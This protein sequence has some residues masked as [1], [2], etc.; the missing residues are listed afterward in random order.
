MGNSAQ[1]G[2]LAWTGRGGISLGRWERILGELPSLPRKACPSC[3]QRR[4]QTA[5]RESTG[6]TDVGGSFL[7]S[8]RHGVVRKEG[9]QPCTGC[10]GEAG[11]QGAASFTFTLS[12][13][14]HGKA[15]LALAAVG[16]GGVD[17][18]LSPAG[19]GL[20]TLISIW[21]QTGRQSLSLPLQHVEGWVQER[22]CSTCSALPRGP[23][24]RLSSI[25]HLS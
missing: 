6:Q 21:Q 9:V 19:R 10:V 23:M 20:L 12:S 18:S 22:S 2:N 4:G 16:A 17:A 25:P 3:R 24:P 5:L 1:N 8:R 13:G 7:P 15:L 11:E 14:T